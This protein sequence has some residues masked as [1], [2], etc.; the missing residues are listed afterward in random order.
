MAGKQ[1]VS[2]G[3]NQ[4]MENVTTGKAPQEQVDM[5]DAYENM[6]M[7]DISTMLN[8]FGKDANAMDAI[9]TSS[10]GYMSLGEFNA[11]TNRSGLVAGKK[12]ALFRSLNDFMLRNVNK[13][14]TMNAALNKDPDA[15]RRNIDRT[16]IMMSLMNKSLTKAVGGK[17]DFTKGQ[18]ATEEMITEFLIQQGLLDKDK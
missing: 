2:L 6:A 4:L 12:E 16:Q 17:L 8:L 5:L 11:E 15:K 3:M 9:K 10:E 7:G 13:D 1:T 14:L 18:S